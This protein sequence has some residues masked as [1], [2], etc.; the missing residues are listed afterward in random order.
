MARRGRCGA[1]R[2][3]DRTPRLY[4]D[5][6]R[7]ALLR[8][9]LEEP[10]PISYSSSL[11]L[12]GPGKFAIPPLVFTNVAQTEG[13]FVLHLGTSLCGHEGI[14]HGGLLATILDEALAR[15]AFLGLPGGIGVTATLGL[16]YRKPTWA[17]AYVVLRTKLVKVQGR[18]A[19][20][21]GHVEDLEGTVLVDAEWVTMLIRVCTDQAQ[22]VVRRA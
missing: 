21:Q 7:S 10:V 8:T 19:W 4:Q 3:A 2:R 16:K 9:S 14:I 6:T 18:K 15:T 13:I 5:R 11:S 12:R 1:G 20:V 17:G 22:G